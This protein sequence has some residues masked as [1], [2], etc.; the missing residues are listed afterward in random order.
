MTTASSHIRIEFEL[1]QDDLGYPP[2]HSET[3]AT[4]TPDGLWQIDNI[5][6]YAVG[7]AL[8]D[9]VQVFDA[10]GAL[11]KF[12]HVVRDAGHGTI[13]IIL[14]ETADV[15]RLRTALRDMGCSTELS[16]TPLRVAVDV[17]PTVNFRDV[18]DF[19]EGYD[20]TEVIDY[21]EGCVPASCA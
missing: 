12:S 18:S 14:S 1:V 2:F 19:V 11:P 15:D 20:Q 6:F 21:D 10:E 13:R 5:P 16:Q 3:R 8:G 7:L 4:P 9:V 17:P